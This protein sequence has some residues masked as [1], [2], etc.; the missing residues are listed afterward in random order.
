MQIIDLCNPIGAFDTHLAILC[1]LDYISDW[2][3]VHQVTDKWV[4][5]PFLSLFQFLYIRTF[6]CVLVLPSALWSALISRHCMGSLP[7]VPCQPQ[8]SRQMWRT[9][10]DTCQLCWYM[11]MQSG[12]VA[13]HQKCCSVLG[14]L[15]QPVQWMKMTEVKHRQ[16]NCVHHH[17]AHSFWYKD[18]YYSWKTSSCKC[19]DLHGHLSFPSFYE[20]Q[21]SANRL[22]RTVAAV[23]PVRCRPVPPGAHS[24][25]CSHWRDC[26]EAS[27][28]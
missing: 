8:F 22:S 16:T 27:Q 14:G 6:F 1:L 23:L 19:L 2:T 18:D 25:W 26:R 15:G 13:W 20:H 10:Q 11:W 28:S 5:S 17:I 4:V 7:A 12:G 9:L 21:R 24:C 3:I